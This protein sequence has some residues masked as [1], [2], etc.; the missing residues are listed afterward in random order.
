MINLLAELVT[1][2]GTKL[3][4]VPGESIFY[5]NWPDV[6]SNCV[7]LQENKH[8]FPVPVQ[9]NASTHHIQITTRAA[10]SD[11]AYQLAAECYRWLLTDDA[12]YAEETID[13][14][15][16][17]GFIT[18]QNDI[19]V[20]VQLH[21]TPLWDKT[22]QQGRRYYYFTATLITKRII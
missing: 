15:D 9:I 21:G 22:D 8:S 18:L 7:L 14:I 11:E 19:S 20:Y 13:V 12:N 6:P 16:T 1:Y 4:L 5:N 3:S 17:T 2:L 10:T